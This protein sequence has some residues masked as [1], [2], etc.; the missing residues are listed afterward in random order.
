[1]TDELEPVWFVNRT[2][3]RNANRDTDTHGRPH[4]GRHQDRCKS[5]SSP[6]RYGVRR[7]R[8]AGP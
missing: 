1:M 6:Q 8:T 3:V 2:I 5:R 7:R 4:A